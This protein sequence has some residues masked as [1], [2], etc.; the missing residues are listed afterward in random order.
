MYSYG[1]AE[2]MFRTAASE[3][4]LIQGAACGDR[5]RVNNWLLY[6]PTNLFEER[7]GLQLPSSIAV[8]PNFPLG[9]TKMRCTS[10]PG[11]LCDG[12]LSATPA[13]EIAKDFRRLSL[14][15]V[16]PPCGS[17]SSPTSTGSYPSAAAHA[18]GSSVYSLSDE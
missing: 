8:S 7:A 14:D 12:V 17:L 1:P 16:A 10:P 2:L 15:R 18:V 3:M 11:L 13:I 6:R 5:W 9:D 4:A